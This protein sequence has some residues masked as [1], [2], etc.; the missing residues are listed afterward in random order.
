MH[1]SAFIIFAALLVVIAAAFIFIAT[2]D[3]SKSDGALNIE[4]GET[5]DKYSLDIYTPLDEIREKEY[6]KL[7][8]V[9]KTRSI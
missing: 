8:I 5:K 1:T 2:K 9:I 3:R 7:K 4:I 6:I